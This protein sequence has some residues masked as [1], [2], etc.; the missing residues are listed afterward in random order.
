MLTFLCKCPLEDIP[1]HF[2]LLGFAVDDGFDYLI[3]E[4]HHILQLIL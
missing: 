4:G 1:F 3:V 2:E